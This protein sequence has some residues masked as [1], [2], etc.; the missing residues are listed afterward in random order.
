MK[1]VITK[2]DRAILI[3]LFGLL[4]LG[5]VYYFIYMNYSDKTAML[6]QENAA[7][8]GRVDVLQGIAD[9]QAELVAKTNSNNEE[10]EKLI[11]RFP[12]NVYEEDVILF[13]RGLEDFSPFENMPT[14]TIGAP[15]EKYKFAN[16]KSQTDEVVNGFIPA[17]V[18]AGAPQA[19][20]V[21]AEG[22]PA[23]ETSEAPKNND[24]LPSLYTRSIGITGRTDY[25]GF[26]NAVKYIVDNSDRSNLTISA[27]Y[28][29][30][31]G[32]LQASINLGRYYV[33]GTN[34][35]Y[36]EPDIPGVIQGTD[37]IFGNVSLEN[38]RP[39]RNP[40]GDSDNSGNGANAE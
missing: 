11:D 36:I 29:I 1:Y 21:P 10:A 34:K 31:T 3:A 17:E 25:D 24:V 39:L 40:V 30:E 37:N 28:D 23:P 26:K 15:S 22:E 8:Q 7:L 18:V 19:E 16:I 13:A 6:K 9:Q 32:M 2:R 12:S 20:P 27:N 35:A 4:V 5:G 38:S 14:I 33:T